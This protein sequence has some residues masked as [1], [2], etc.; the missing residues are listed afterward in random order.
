VPD[1]SIAVR[2]QIESAGDL[3]PT[4]HRQQHRT[5]RA[6]RVDYD[7]LAPDGLDWVAEQVQGSQV[8]AFGSGLACV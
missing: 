8:F 7:V 6:I 4:L 3:R 2:N 1:Q 5:D